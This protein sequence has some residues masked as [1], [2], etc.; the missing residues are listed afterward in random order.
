MQKKIIV[1]ALMSA[2]AAPAAF[3]DTDKAELEKLR[4]MVQELDRKIRSLERE[5]E[6]KNETATP[7][8]ATANAGPA[9]NANTTA[10]ANTLSG[11]TLYGQVDLSYDSI[12]NGTT[13]AGVAGATNNKVSSNVS[14]FGIKGAEDLG[15]GLSAIWQIEQQVDI[16]AAAANTLASR[17]SFLGLSDNRMGK[18]LLGRHDTPYKLATRNLDIFADSIGDNRALMGGVKAGAYGAAT[19]NKSSVVGFDERPTDIIAYFTPDIGGFTGALAYVNRTEANTLASQAKSS[20]TSVAGMY[21]NGP[22]FGS[23]AYET[24]AL[25]PTVPV[26]TANKESAA[27]FGLGYTM[28]PLSVGFAYEKT[29]DNV[30]ALGADLYGHNAYYLSG[31]YKSGRGAVK[32]AYTKAG[33]L[34]AA[35]NTGADQFALGYDHSMSKRTTLYGVY[36]RL[37]NQSAI[38]YGL[39]TNATGGGTTTQAGAGASPSALSLGIRHSF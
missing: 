16:D 34:G 17:N 3:A 26:P 33:Q 12:R 37:S 14:K 15:D 2:F 29:S 9:A 10:N 24:H 22:F 8:R 19:A 36:T 23:L 31:K 28:D 25:A 6:R 39:T 21:R 18:V 27:K 7:A 38:N 35:A 5:M 1:L 30:G 20:I 32:L 11:I 13:A 4:A